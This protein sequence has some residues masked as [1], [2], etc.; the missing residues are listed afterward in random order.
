MPSRSPL[1]AAPRAASFPTMPKERGGQYRSARARREE[2][3]FR[4]YEYELSL[5]QRKHLKQMITEERSSRKGVVWEGTEWDLK[6]FTEV[7][8]WKRERK[9]RHMKVHDETDNARHGRPPAPGDA[10][11]ENKDDDEDDDD[12]Y[13]DDDVSKGCRSCCYVPPRI[14]G[15]ARHGTARHGTRFAHPR[16]LIP[17]THPHPHCSYTCPSS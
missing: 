1:L 7:R 13:D 5:L 14:H 4:R 12:D 10:D 3:E 8:G 11:G 2:E 15:T 9:V 6:T 16:L 17:Y